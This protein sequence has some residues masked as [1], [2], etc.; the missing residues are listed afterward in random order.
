MSELLNLGYINVSDILL[1]I[2]LVRWTLMPLHSH[3]T[4]TYPTR[5]LMVWTM[6]FI[7]G[8]LGF[9]ICASTVAIRDA[10]L[11]S[12]QTQSSSRFSS[13]SSVFIVLAIAGK[14]DL[15]MVQ[16]VLIT[17]DDLLRPQSTLLRSIPW[18]AFR[19]FEAAVNEVGTDFLAEVWTYSFRMARSS[20]QKLEIQS[21]RVNIFLQSNKNEQFMPENHKALVSQF[22]PFLPQLCEPAMS[23]YVPSDSRAKGWQPDE[24]MERLR[25]LRT[26]EA[27]LDQTTQNYYILI[28]VLLGSIYG[29]CSCACIQGKSQLAEDSDMV[30]SAD[31]IYEN[32]ARRLIHW[33]KSLGFALRDGIGY[34][35]WSDLIFELFLSPSTPSAPSAVIDR[36]VSRRDSAWV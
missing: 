29:L 13:H 24:I 25:C 3:P 18:L 4:N 36:V 32:G 34:D 21:L 12:E 10:E 14:T 28:S 19:H 2:G 7:L 6:A 5:S 16:K 22:S 20:F 11:Y 26:D 23:R 33:A 9:S 15:M 31:T 1:V 8:K 30:F 35:K 27:T 17:D